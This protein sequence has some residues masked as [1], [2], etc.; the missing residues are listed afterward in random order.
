MGVTIYVVTTDDTIVRAT[1]SFGE[2][3]REVER[4]A[5]TVELADGS[6]PF[7]LL[8]IVRCLDGVPVERVTRQVGHDFVG[9]P[10]AWKTKLE[11][12]IV[13]QFL[14]ENGWRIVSD[15]HARRASPMQELMS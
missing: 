15:P 13:E 11:E 8:V 7:S 14:G 9:E 4:L 3:V 6:V 10:L 1:T 2:V 5:L 12:P